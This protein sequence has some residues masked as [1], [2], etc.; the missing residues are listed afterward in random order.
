M[1][2]GKE[3]NNSSTISNYFKFKDALWKMTIEGIYKNR[4]Y[5]EI[6]KDSYRYKNMKEMKHKE[7]MMK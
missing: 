5:K 1:V 6:T 7:F 3:N 2:K 4:K